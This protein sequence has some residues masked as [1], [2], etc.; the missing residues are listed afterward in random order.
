MKSKKPGFTSVD[1]YIAAFP[2]RTKKALEEVRT[3]INSVVPDAL[4]N[5][6]YEMAA[7]KVNG[8]NFIGLAGWK[9]HISIYPIPAGSDAF[10]K[11]ISKYVSGKGTM[12]FPLDQPLPLKLIERAVKYQLADHLKNTRYT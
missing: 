6:S 5:I 9:K 1:E 12:K 7:F 4:E 2:E 11:A 8:K 3:I 10:N